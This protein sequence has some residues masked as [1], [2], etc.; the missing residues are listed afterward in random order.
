MIVLQ[1]RINVKGTSGNGICDFMLQCTDEDYQQWWRGTHL[2]F[3]TIKRFPD[4][5]GNV[6]LFDEFVGKQ[7]FRFEGVIT[8]VIAGKKLV[9]RL[10][11]VV[12]LPAW[13]SLDFEDHPDSVEITHTLSIGFKGAGKILD[14]L[15][16]R[17]LPKGFDRE[18]EEHAQTEFHK[19]AEFLA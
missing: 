3:H 7:R 17:F 14:P 4:H 16:R 11:K 18:L 13:L 8:D 12:K 15:L 6:V 1:T 2:A 10:R 19:L 5:L 9:W